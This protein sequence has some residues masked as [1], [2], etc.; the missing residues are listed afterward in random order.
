MAPT[1]LLEEMSRDCLVCGVNHQ[2]QQHKLLADTGSPSRVPSNWHNLQRRMPLL[3]VAEGVLQL[4]LST[5]LP[6][7][8]PPVTD[9]AT[10]PHNPM[11]A[12]VWQNMQF[13]WSQADTR[14]NCPGETVVHILHHSTSYNK[15]CP[16]TVA[17]ES[18]QNRSPR[19][20]LDR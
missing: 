20:C 1:N 15:C 5:T 17:D 6:T 4:H 12:T 14:N 7:G 11:Q 3:L 13:K 16:H 18:F 19:S 2:G 8:K 9:V 10:S